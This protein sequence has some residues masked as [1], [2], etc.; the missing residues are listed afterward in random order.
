MSEMPAAEVVARYA[1]GVLDGSVTAC[2]WLKRACERHAYDL[3]TGSE[4]GLWFDEQA[5]QHVIDFFGLLRHSKGEWAG[6]TITLEPW[7]QFVL[8]CLFGWMRDDG[9]R[10]FRTSY[11]EVARKNGKSTLAA[12]VGLYLLVADGEPGAE[13]YAAATKYQQAEIVFSEA[14]RMVKSSPA[15]RRRLQVFS[16]NIHITETAS[17][18][19]PVCSQYQTLDGLN[20][21]GAIVDEIHEHPSRNLWDVLVTGT[22]AR[23]QPLVFGITTAGY[24]RQTLCWQ[25]HEYTEKVL[26]QVLVDDSFFG[27]IYCLDAEDDWLDESCWAKANPNLGVSKYL[28]AMQVEAGQAREMPSQTNV[29]QR[30]HLDIWT[31]ASERWMSAEHWEACALGVDA[32]GLRGR[33]C[34]GGLDLSSNV[35]VTALAMV[36]PPETEEE[37]YRAL[38]RF[39]IPQENMLERVRKD[40]VPYDVWVRQGFMAATPGNVIDYGFI[41][42]EV[43]ELMRAYD[44]REIAFDRWGATKVAQS[45]A[46]MAGREDFLVQFGQGFVSMSPP[47]KALETLVLGHRLAHGGNPVLTWMAHNVVASVDAAGNIKPDKARSREKIDGI[48]ALIMGLDRALRHEDSRSVYETRGIREL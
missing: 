42:A 46:E 22:G 44:V 38:L 43:D 45:L 31:Q 33:V 10:R 34:Y 40:R 13:I 48:V 12:G 36:F 30:K 32:A 11:L 16:Q 9:T 27:V 5:G 23:R 37:P 8:W 25:L 6:Q 7:Q 28:K 14:S 39:W 41:L 2:H 29:F 18:M 47:M 20:I 19:E 4:R 15:L 24:D 1:Q 21:H 17:K 35:D 3:A 26:D